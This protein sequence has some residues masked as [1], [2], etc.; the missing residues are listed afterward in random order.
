MN[1]VTQTNKKSFS[2]LVKLVESGDLDTQINSLALINS[3]LASNINPAEEQLSRF[4]END[5]N[6]T[7]MLQ[8]SNKN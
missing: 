1:E 2:Q 3:L 4:N 6:I 7:N 8:V 5:I